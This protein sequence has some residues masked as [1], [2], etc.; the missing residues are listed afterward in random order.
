MIDPEVAK[1]VKHALR[2]FARSIFL[3]VCLFSAIFAVNLPKHHLAWDSEHI[4][5]AAV[6]A[7]IGACAGAL[8][9]AAEAAGHLWK[10][11]K[12]QRSQDQPPDDPATHC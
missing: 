4:S 6:G 11:L 5:W 10:S 9:G 8:A 12:G 7:F 1:A 2:G 3:G